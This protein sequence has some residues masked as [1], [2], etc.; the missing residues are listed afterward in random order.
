MITS[1]ENTKP[2]DIESRESGGTS[3]ILPKE[4]H[5]VSFEVEKLTNILDGG[6]DKTK[7]RRFIISPGE[8][9][10]LSGKYFWERAQMIAEHTKHF[11]KVHEDYWDAIIPSREDVV[12]MVEYSAMSGAFMNHYGLFLPTILAQ[13][14]DEQK[15]LWLFP[16]LQMKMVGAYAQT[17]LGHGSNVRGLQ[18]TA[19]YDVKTQTFVLNTPTLRSMKWWPGALGRI[20]T[21]AVVYA[22]LIIN[23]QEYGV[24]SFMLQ[25][26][27]ENHKTYPGIEVG[28]LGPK[29]GD[30]ANDTGYMRLDNVRIPLE[31]ML[32]KYQQVTPEGKYIK[33][34]AKQENSKLHYSTMMSARGGMIKGAGGALAK[35][36]TIAIRYSLVRTQGYVDTKAVSSYLADE[37]SII[38]Y[39]VQ[40]YRLFKQLALV[41][42]IKF[43]GMWMTSTFTEIDKSTDLGGFAD[44]LPE[45][46]ATSSGLKAL[47][48]VLAWTG[49]EDCRKCCGGNGYLLAGGIAHLAADYVWQTTAEGDWIILMLQTAKFLMK[50]LGN[51]KNGKPVSGPISYLTVLHKNNEITDFTQFAPP[52]ASFVEQFFNLGYLEK[53]FNYNALLAVTAA[54]QDFDNKLKKYG[55]YDQAWNMCALEMCNAVKAHCFSFML[56]NFVE[57]V[58]RETEPTIKP[59]LEQLCALYACSVI[60]DE[61][62]WSGT[63]ALPQ[64]RLA[65]AA[66]GELLEK[67]RPNAIGL[68]DAFDIPDRILNSAIGGYDGNVY[69]SLYENALRNPLN[70]QEPF[71]GYEYLKPHLDLEN[72]KLGN[73]KP[74]L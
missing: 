30:H 62:V 32:N 9:S 19:I 49:I 15:G 31:Y 44:A 58:N 37:V 69:E 47:C 59:V 3:H 63:L 8:N 20:C 10:D 23:G 46:A 24:H 48:T 12:W 11:I 22:Q 45:I 38:D 26:R 54:G 6:V 17:E 2:S 60:A 57:Q 51:A 39:Q 64:V 7:R 52:A 14:S 42:A 70:K 21:H 53:L 65:K 5:G 55:K 40:R 35:A 28:D 13:A 68:V 67:L 18:T 36:V 66:I 73:V 74:N 56:H 41:Y 1:F 43:T 50:S 29:L 25:V 27:D 16:T 4:R 61:A 71:F 34:K 72:L 33:S